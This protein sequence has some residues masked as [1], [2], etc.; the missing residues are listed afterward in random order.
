MSGRSSRAG[1]CL[2]LEFDRMKRGFVCLWIAA[3]LL[4]SGCYITKQ[5]PKFDARA[6]RNA[7]VLANLTTVESTNS[8]QQAWLSPSADFF[9]LGP[10][11]HLEIEILGE[12]GSRA[13][14]IVG[15]DGKIYYYVLPGIDVWGLTLDE[16]KGR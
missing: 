8:I 4:L 16:A 9:K 15:P 1:C 3:G 2:L 7:T 11:D 12:A 10:G 6:Y 13:P 14:V 5:G